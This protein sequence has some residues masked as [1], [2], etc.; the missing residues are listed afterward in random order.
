MERGE[1]TT[2]V[3]REDGLS[4]DRGRKSAT[5]TEVVDGDTINI[6]PAINGNDE[7]RLIGMDTPETKDPSEEIES[8]GPE[9][10][11]YAVSKLTGVDV[12]LEFDQERTDQYGRLLAYLYPAGR[13][14]FNVELVEEGYAQAY[15]YPPN[16]RHEDRFAAAQDEARSAGLGIWGLSERQ[17]CK[18]ADRGNGIGEGTPGCVVE[19][20]PEPT[21][22]QSGGDLD[23][24]E[25][26]RN[27][28]PARRRPRPPGTGLPNCEARLGSSP[29]SSSC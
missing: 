7:V 20:P 11:A 3:P 22:I 10:S 27:A 9:A 6:F 21:P 2:S 25:F 12:E 24:S 26:R 8:Y 16:T 23:R 1:E 15:H 19:A 5:V 13:L 14:M 28:S 18:L 4:A 17:Q 29:A